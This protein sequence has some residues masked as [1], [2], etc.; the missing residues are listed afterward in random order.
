[1][2]KRKQYTCISFLSVCFWTLTLPTHAGQ[3]SIGATVQVGNQQKFERVKALDTKQ[4]TR[5]ELQLSKLRARIDE[6]RQ[7]NEPQTQNITEHLARMTPDKMIVM[8]LRGG[9]YFTNRGKKNNFRVADRIL[10]MRE[11]NGCKQIT[12]YG[13]VAFVEKGEM[14]FEF[15]SGSSI[16]IYDEVYVVN[17]EDTPASIINAFQH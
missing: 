9:L 15:L 2:T 3:G 8:G 1:M 5:L 6:L 14:S 10:T 11:S 13:V 17:R 7:V 12:G 4:I 16:K